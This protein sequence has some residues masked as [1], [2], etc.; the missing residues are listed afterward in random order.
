M[1]GKIELELVAN[2]TPKLQQEGMGK[3]VARQF[4]TIRNV[5]MAMKSL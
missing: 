2:S 1:I 5:V 3:G 4:F